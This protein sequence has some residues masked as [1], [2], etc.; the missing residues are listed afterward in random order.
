MITFHGYV[1]DGGGS[2]A[3]TIPYDTPG[4][5]YAKGLRLCFVED[6]AVDRLGYYG[7]S[8][9]NNEP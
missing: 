6:D 3:S 8:R 7:L 9:D 2:L 4:V 1:M 5:L